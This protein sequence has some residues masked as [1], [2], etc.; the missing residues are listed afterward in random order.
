[1]LDQEDQDEA[2]G[3]G[4]NHALSGITR[5]LREA[6]GQRMRHPTFT[7]TVKVNQRLVEA[8]LGFPDTEWVM[9]KDTTGRHQ[10]QGDSWV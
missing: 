4:G 7:E 3:V 10:E 9:T 5:L 1:M 8:I 2:K 6:A